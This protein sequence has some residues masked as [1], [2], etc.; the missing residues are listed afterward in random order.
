MSEDQSILEQLQKIVSEKTEL[1]LGTLEPS[2]N[3][4]DSGLDSFAKINLVMEI[5][6]Y[7]DFE[8]TDSE[9]ASIATISDLIEKIK[10]K[11]AVA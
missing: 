6:E 2:L 8:L 1:D 5:E 10:S 11:K 9:S 4:E 7:Y 3:L